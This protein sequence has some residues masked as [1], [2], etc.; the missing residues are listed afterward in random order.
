MTTNRS[1]NWRSCG[2]C[3]QGACLT[4]GSAGRTRNAVDDRDVGRGRGRG[5]GVGQVERHV[6][7]DQRVRAGRADRGVERRGGVRQR[8]GVAGA[9]HRGPVGADGGRLRGGQRGLGGD[10]Q[11]LVGGRRLDGRVGQVGRLVGVGDVA[12]AAG[13]VRGDQVAPGRALVAF[14]AAGAP[15]VPPVALGV[16]QLGGRQHGLEG[17]DGAVVGVDA[18][19][20]PGRCRA[21]PRWSR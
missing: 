10:D 19:Q 7:G 20:E 12:G 18:D 2:A 4:A 17:V 5:R 14:D 16:R 9:P 13:A 8:G 11:D 21:G 3:D 1:G 15:D 6:A